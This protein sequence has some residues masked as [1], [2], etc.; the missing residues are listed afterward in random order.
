MKFKNKI[1][2]FLGFGKKE[3]E[4]PPSH[5]GLIRFS[6]HAKRNGT[7]DKENAEIWEYDG[8]KLVGSPHPYSEELV[9]SMRE[10]DEIPV[11]WEKYIDEDFELEEVADF[12]QVEFRK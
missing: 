10:I 11:V 6:K 1:L 5:F 7:S 3:K 9:K 4:T 2:R 8:G 12:G